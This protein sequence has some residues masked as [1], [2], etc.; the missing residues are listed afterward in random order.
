MDNSLT[1]SFF[2][3]YF[4]TKLLDTIIGKRH[5]DKEQSIED[6]ILC[7]FNESLKA[8]CDNH[9]IE[10]DGESFQRWY[11]SSSLTHITTRYMH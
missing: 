3:E 6:L 9:E 7:L 4:A 8:F 1:S 10:F 2:M 5:H 11:E